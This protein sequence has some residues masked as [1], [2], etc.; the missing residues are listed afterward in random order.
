MNFKKENI[1]R[2]LRFYVFNDNRIYTDGFKSYR[3]LEDYF[4]EHQ[5]VNHKKEYKVKNT[6]IHTNTIE[7]NW[8]VL[9]RIIKP[10]YRTL[11]RILSF[12][13]KFMIKCNEK[14]NCFIN[15]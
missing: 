6:D 11:K 1:P 9:K 15:F 13:V 4:I 10:K 14:G 2:L 5:F 8:S 3:G 7:A 12:L